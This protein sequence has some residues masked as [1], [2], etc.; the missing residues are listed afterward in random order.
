MEQDSMTRQEK[1]RHKVVLELV[2]RWQA[3]LELTNYRLQVSPWPKSETEKREEWA[4]VSMCELSFQAHIC[5]NPTLDFDDTRSAIVH[6]LCHLLTDH[7]R[8]AVNRLANTGIFT[9]QGWKMFCSE[10][11]RAQELNTAHLEKMFCSLGC[12]SDKDLVE[13]FDDD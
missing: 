9:D 12:W 3:R 13:G 2:E 11:D 10:F 7:T 6:E 8:H 4:A 1:R 5:Y